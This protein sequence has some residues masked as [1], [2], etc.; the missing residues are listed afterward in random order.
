MPIKNCF[1][2]EITRKN[3]NHCFLVVGFTDD[4]DFLLVSRDYSNINDIWMVLTDADILLLCEAI[5]LLV[6]DPPQLKKGQIPLPS[7]PIEGP[8]EL[9][10]AFPNQRNEPNF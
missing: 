8:Y 9:S 3:F 2:I 1:A 10:P 7:L 5:L 6:N 4:H